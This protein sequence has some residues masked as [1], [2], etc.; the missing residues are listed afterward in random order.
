M[1]FAEP[2]YLG[3]LLLLPL[4]ALAGLLLRRRRRRILAR[5]AGGPQLV[6]R[7]TGQV[8][9][10]RR[11]LKLLLLH[12]AL[13]AIPLAL[14]RPQW[15]TRLEPIER[16]GADVVVVLDTSLSMATEDL[17]PSRLAHAK[18]SIDAV[19]SRLAG[20]R[21][22][23]VTFAGEAALE[24]PLTVDQG[25]VRLFLDAVDVHSVSRGGS[26]LAGALR[27]ALGALRLDEPGDRG[28][29]ILLY[30]DGEDHEGGVDRVVAEFESAGVPIF[31]VGTGTV[32]G[33]PIPL[34]DERGALTGYKKDRE[35]RVVTSRLDE[36]LLGRIALD[37]EG[38]YHGA[39]A[40]ELEVEPIAEALGAL[41]AGDL[42]TELRSRYEE[43]FQLP[44]A[45]GWLALAIETV[46][47]D[48]RGRPAAQ[49]EDG[50]R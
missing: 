15:G 16:R 39:T 22:A 6:E 1:R 45:L 40:G 35:G 7:F 44:L 42:G 50:G 18:H 19:L 36:A 47:S 4:V 21:V 25:A 20:D 37:T 33:G 9:P 24:C 38:R 31:V 32:R 11:A 14:A 43:R 49:R 8:S 30:T 2:A 34:R 3:L 27:V 13:A 10:H 29:A 46:L 41:A 26:G 23:L 5:F 28:R 48:R 17:A 12:L